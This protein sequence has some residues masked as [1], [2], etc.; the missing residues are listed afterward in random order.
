MNKKGRAVDNIYIEGLRRSIKYED[1]YL[2]SYK[3]ERRHQNLN[4]S[5]PAEVFFV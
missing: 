4:Y 2:K 5:T 1:L 3:N